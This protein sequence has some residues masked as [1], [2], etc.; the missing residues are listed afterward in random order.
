MKFLFIAALCIGAAFAE[1][2]Q[3]QE[4]LHEQSLADF[5]KEKGVGLYPNPYD[6]EL[7]TFIR[8]ELEPVELQCDDGFLFDAE[9]LM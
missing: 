5:C 8:C 3:D 6:P 4:V 1:V 7:K 2:A 9:K